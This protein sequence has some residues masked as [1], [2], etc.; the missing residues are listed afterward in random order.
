[1]S[2]DFR[3]AYLDMGAF[4]RRA[5]QAN[6]DKIIADALVAMDGLLHSVFEAGDE[7]KWTDRSQRACLLDLRHAMIPLGAHLGVLDPDIIAKMDRAES[8]SPLAKPKR[9]K[10]SEKTGEVAA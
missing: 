3:L 7:P 8:E 4:A 2:T 9:T 5:D 6:L 1:M 10:E